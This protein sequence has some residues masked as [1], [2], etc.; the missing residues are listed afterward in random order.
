MRLSI[1][2]SH[3]QYTMYKN[4]LNQ[5][6]AQLAVTHK[7]VFV[8]IHMNLLYQHIEKGGGAIAHLPL[9]SGSTYV[10][11]NLT[12]ITIDILQ[13]YIVHYRIIYWVMRILEL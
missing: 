13:Y 5:C 11:S 4:C 2:Y 3:V 7:T 8:I 9:P 10:N 1:G 6:M 12:I